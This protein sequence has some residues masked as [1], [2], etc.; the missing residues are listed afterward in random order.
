MDYRNALPRRK[1]LYTLLCSILTAFAFLAGCTH[2]RDLPPGT[3]K[4][5]ASPVVERETVQVATAEQD[6]PPPA[7]Y[8]IGPND[9][10]AI[11]VS[12]KP[13]FIAILAAGNNGKLLGNR[14]DGSGNIRLPLV[15]TIPVAGLTL[16]QAQGR[17]QEAMKKYYTDPWVTVEIADYKSKS[18]YLLGQFKLPG[19]FYMDRPLNLV[20]GLALGSGPDPTGD[21]RGAKL[22]RAGKIMPVD[23][24]DLLTQGD[25]HQNIWLQPGDTIYIPD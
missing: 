12:N 23:I 22:T 14:V 8:V 25:T 4:E 6:A 3:V 21:L 19:T 24:Y 11:N 2:Y 10:L 9:A 17:I 20:Q 5:I 13:E 16:S 7:D 15:G 18:L 1:T